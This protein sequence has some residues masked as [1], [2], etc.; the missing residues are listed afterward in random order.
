[1]AAGILGALIATYGVPF[2]DEKFS[3]FSDQIKLNSSEENSD[4]GRFIVINEEE[5]VIKVVEKA[6]PA[7]V[8]IV[9]AK[10]LPVIE[11]RFIDPF[12]DPF[13]REFFKPF[14]L[15]FRIPDPK[16]KGV[17][18][19]EV[20]AG[21]GFLISSDGLILTNR[22]VIDIQGADFTVLLNDGRK[23]GAKILGKDPV[24]DLAIIKI[25]GF[26]FPNLTL[27]NSDKLKIGHTVIAIGNALGQFSNTVSKGVIS[28][29][30]RSVT[31]T[32][33]QFS[34]KLE[35][36]IQT[37]AAINR[38]NS[39]GP[40]LNLRGEVIGV[41]TAIAVGAENISFSIPI[42]RAKKDIED[43][44][45]TGKIIAPFIGVRYTLITS[46]IAGENDLPINYGALIV[47]GGS[48]DNPA[49]VPGSPAEK[50]GLKEGDIILEIENKRISEGNDLSKAIL[51]RKVG[52][53]VSVKIL[54]QGQV[55]NLN[56]V[57]GER[58]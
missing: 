24:Q 10:D 2:I 47:S 22:H 49:V 29:L 16:Q 26:G 57:L 19:Q 32:S 1:M 37:D 35:S 9:A 5:Q 51:G 3:D 33:G 56:V 39:G 45:K 20:S 8:S 7:V 18:K 31:A 36:V 12:E 25:D 23:F 30:S 17:Q 13:F 34:E 48:A 15:D 28:G 50:A 21:T 58:P 55:L 38:G 4:S 46:S 43:V 11:Q 41:N 27:G 14:G 6:S 42:N 54:R 40:L 53:A 52:D 44:R